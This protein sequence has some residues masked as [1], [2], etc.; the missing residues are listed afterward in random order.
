M[1]LPQGPDDR[2]LSRAARPRRLPRR[3]VSRC[4]SRAHLVQQAVRL[5]LHRPAASRR[6]RASLRR[7]LMRRCGR[8][9]T[10]QAPPTASR[11]QL[12]RIRVLTQVQSVLDAISVFNLNQPT[13]HT[14]NSC[15]DLTMCGHMIKYDIACDKTYLFSFV[16]M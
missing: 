4:R 12:L 3:L 1:Q 9:Q 7:Q 16:H 2:A 13:R 15:S 14:L 6:G 11:L 10:V 8:R 5:Q